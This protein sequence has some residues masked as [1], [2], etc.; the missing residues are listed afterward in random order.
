MVFCLF[1]FGAVCIP[2]L[3]GEKEFFVIFTSL[4]SSQLSAQKESGLISLGR[5][6]MLVEFQSWIEIL[7]I[8]NLNPALLPNKLKTLIIW[9]SEIKTIK[10]Y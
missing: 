1:F 10:Y 9:Y 7:V 3:Y 2:K 5:K 6:L 8:V 4:S